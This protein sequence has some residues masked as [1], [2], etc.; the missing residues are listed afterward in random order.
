M[1]NYVYSGRELLSFARQHYGGSAV[2]SQCG[3]G[4]PLPYR[5][6]PEVLRNSW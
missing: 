3:H 4:G 6:S 1:G 2:Q 5:T